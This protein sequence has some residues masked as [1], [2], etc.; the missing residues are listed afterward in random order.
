VLVLDYGNLI[1]DGLPHVVQQD[2]RVIDA[3]FG[4]ARRETDG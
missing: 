1:A 4:T 3:Y 2:T